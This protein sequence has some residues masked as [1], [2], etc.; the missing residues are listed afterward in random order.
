MKVFHIATGFPI[1][2]PGGIT[3]YVRTLSR[4]QVALGHHVE[5]LAGLENGSRPI[6]YANVVHQFK[7]VGS[8]FCLSVNRDDKKAAGVLREE[9]SH[10][11]IIHFHMGYGLP[12]S[13]YDMTMPVPYI[14]SLHDYGLIC[15]RIFMMDKWGQLCSHRDLSRCRSCV[16]LLEQVN[17]LR[18]GFGRMRWRLPT[19][20]S[21]AVASRAERMDG[22]L[23]R[24]RR[25]LAVSRR[26]S[27]I[28]EEAIPGAGCDVLHIGNESAGEVQRRGI[29]APSGKIRCAFIG[30]LNRDKGAEV[31]IELVRMLPSERFEFTFWGRGE[32]RYVTA[33]SS[34]GVKCN[35]AYRPG[36]I[37][38]I[39][40]EVDVGLVLPIW[41]D[42]GPQVLMELLNNGIP[43]LGTDRGGIPDFL[44]PETGFLFDPSSG[45][46]NAAKWLQAVDAD[47]LAEM[48]SKIS[49]LKTPTAHCTEVVNVYMQALGIEE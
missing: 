21:D 46:E 42:N 16:G 24:A 35:G 14:V 6:D 28:F 17:V 22:F 12:A 29:W 11:D 8:A 38:G 36:D 9:L 23:R 20:P 5:I 27:E 31:F 7:G 48:H 19:L 39:L 32:A 26:V 3:N 37:K 43:V 13:F 33:L 10:F 34:L 49:P 25:R 41:N 45:V 47:K 2:F 44:T 40:Q 18:A 1:S 15:P 30:T 4:A